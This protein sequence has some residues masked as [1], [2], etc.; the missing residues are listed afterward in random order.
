M[1]GYTGVT[2][3]S[4]LTGYTGLTGVSGLT[5]YTGVTGLWPSFCGTLC[6]ESHCR[7][8]SAR[9]SLCLYAHPALYLLKAVDRYKAD[10]LMA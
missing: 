4:G 6:F 8:T 5:G 10:T 3:V 7:Q 9:M 2:G 1:T